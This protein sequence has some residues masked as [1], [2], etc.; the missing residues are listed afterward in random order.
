MAQPVWLVDAY[1]RLLRDDETKDVD[2]ETAGGTLRAHSLILSA[3]SDAFQGLLR[4]QS[5]AAADCATG[6]ASGKR[7]LWKEHSQDVARFFL[8]LLYTGTVCEQEW[9]GCETELAR[10]TENQ[11]PIRLL[12]GSLTLAK[13]YIVPHLVHHLTEELRARINVETFN[14]ICSGATAFC[15]S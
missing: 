11:V 14:D 13:M 7:L 5:I 8:R 9:F 6:D 3:H 4:C 12:L 2:I 15:N 1:E 10:D